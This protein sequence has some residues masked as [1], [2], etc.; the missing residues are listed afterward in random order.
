M[1]PWPSLGGEDSHFEVLRV[2]SPGPGACVVKRCHAADRGRDDLTARLRNEALHLTRLR[3]LAVPAVHRVSEQPTSLVTRYIPGTELHRW[4][5][6]E[7]SAREVWELFDRLLTVVESVHARGTVHRDL[8]PA[9]I[10]VDEQG[11]PWLVDFELACDVDAPRSMGRSWIEQEAGTPPYAS[12]ELRQDPMRATGVQVDVFALGVLLDELRRGLRGSERLDY[13]IVR[14]TAPDPAD[15]LR[16]VSVFRQGF[17]LVSGP[18]FPLLRQLR[19]L[20]T[21]RGG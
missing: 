18:R 1:S 15:R 19:R 12:P 16:N 11:H 8:K 9:N 10:M 7:R 6:T 21:G 14:A 2:G 13:L 4:M 5:D 20:V 17:A 3:G